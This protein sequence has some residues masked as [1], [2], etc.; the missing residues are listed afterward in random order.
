MIFYILMTLTAILYGLSY[1]LP[2]NKAATITDIYGDSSYGNDRILSVKNTGY[3]VDGRA[4]LSAQD[5]FTHSVVVAP[6]G[7]GKTVTS[8][9]PNILLLASDEEP[10]SLVI[11]DIKSELMELT[12]SYLESKGYRVMAIDFDQPDISESFN[13]LVHLEDESMIKGFCNMLF[14]I[15]NEKATDSIDGLWKHGSIELAQM[16]ISTMKRV[17]N[18]NKTTLATLI[19]LLNQMAKEDN[20]KLD[21]FIE[22]HATPQMKT[23]Y[24]SARSAEKKI[25]FGKLSSSQAT[26][27]LYDIPKIRAVTSSNTIN[28]EDFRK[29][30]IA[31]FL[32]FPIT[33]TNEYSPIISVFL[34]Q[35]FS[36]LLKTPL[37]KNDHPIYFAL[38]EFGNIKIPNFSKICTLIRSQKCSLNIILQSI[39]QLDEKYTRSG[40]DIILA[41]LSTIVALKGLRDERSLKYISSLIGST[42]KSIYTMGS[43]GLQFFNAKLITEGQLRSLGRKALFLHGDKAPQRIST[44][45]IYKNKQLM[46]QASLVS[47]DGQLVPLFPYQP[48][49]AAKEKDT[50]IDTKKDIPPTEETNKQEEVLDLQEHPQREQPDPEIEAYKKKLAELLQ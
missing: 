36:Y 33:L 27:T 41:N 26:F 20:P 42:T 29:E 47:V 9:I 18:Q 12:G 23:I 43:F 5:S 32:R 2:I 22:D 10:K 45:P 44:T 13:P 40:A 3:V 30:K 38:D 25:F 1:V 17:P 37:Q 31:L 39:G 11:N 24:E 4:R 8:I 16:L 7:A 46:E 50:V 28:F 15:G 34:S 6:S 48:T 49:T 19:Y 14:S 21:K 35:F